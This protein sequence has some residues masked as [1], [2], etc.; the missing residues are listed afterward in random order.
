V[1]IDHRD[2]F[3]DVTMLDTTDSA[4]RVQ[5]DAQ[6]RLGLAGRFRVTVEMSEFTRE[7]AQAGLR[8]RRP[9]LGERELRLEL[10]RQ[11]YG[12]EVHGP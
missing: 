1:K 12:F 4:A 8:A 3:R 10:L 9:H 11:L 2:T 7:L 6:R 5:L